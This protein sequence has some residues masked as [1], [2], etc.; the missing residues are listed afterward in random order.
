LTGEIVGQGPDHEPVVTD[1]RG[2]SWVGQEALDEALRRYHECFDV[3]RDS[4]GHDVV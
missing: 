2:V 3:G 4:R 1:M